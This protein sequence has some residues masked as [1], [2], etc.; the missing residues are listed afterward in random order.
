MNKLFNY[1]EILSFS[2]ALNPICW[3][4]NYLLEIVIKSLFKVQ[5]KVMNAII[6]NQ[7]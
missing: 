7:L 2:K 1:Y 3:L 5:V 4:N 6:E